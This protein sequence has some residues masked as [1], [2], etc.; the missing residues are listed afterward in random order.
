MKAGVP[1]HAVKL[2]VCLLLSGGQIFAQQPPRA[3]PVEEERTAVP[4]AVPVDSPS[5]ASRP[6]QPSA[7]A[8][9]TPRAQG[10]DE[11]L[12]EY[13]TL[14]FAQQD[15]AIAIKPLSDYVRTYPQGRHAA[16]ALFRL[17]ES[18]LKVGDANEAKKAYSDVITRY[19]KTESAASAA[20]RLGALIYNTK[21]FIKAAGYFETCAR[22]TTSA[23]VKLAALYN[24]ALCYKQ[25]DQ[26]AK[27]LAS[28][29]AVVAI[30]DPNQY[31]D[32]A[33]L[34]VAA[35]S[36][37]AGKKEEAL[38][39]FNQ[40]IE[41]NKDDKVIG[42]ALLKAGLILNEQGKGEAA[43][44]NFKRALDM[45]GLSSDQRGVA[46]FGLIQGY[47]VTGDYDNVIN[48]YSANASTLPPEDLRSKMLLLVGNAHKQKQ[49]YRQAV[50]VFLLLEKNHPDSPESL[51]AGYQKLL[52]FYQLG[53]KDVPVFS[54]RFEERYGDKYR[55]HEYLRMSRLI[56]A[57][58]Y[59]ANGKY[60]ES[61]VA[62]SGI[63]MAAVPPKVRA[64]VLYKKGFAEA[65][66][67]KSN[68]AISS[69][70]LYLTDYPKDD[71]A[72]LALAQRGISYKAVRS[73]DRALEDFRTIIKDYPGHSAAE[74][75]YYQSGL[76]KGETRDL[77]GM[78]ADLEA[79]VAKFPASPAAAESFFRIG[80]GYF[81]MK[82]KETYR[83]ALAPLRKSIELDSKEYLD[84]GSQLLIACQWLLEDVDGLANE[85]DKY[86]AARKDASITPKALTFL[87]VNYYNQGKFRES[88]RYLNI[89]STPDAPAN[90]EAV[91][92]DYLGMAEFE[93]GNHEAALKAFDNYLAQTPE[94]A[95]RVRALLN[96]SRAFLALGKFDEAETTAIEGLQV[97]RE[98]DLHAK[99]QILQ[100]DIAMAH[101]DALEAAGNKDAGSEEWKKAAGNFVVVSQ[102][103]VHPEITPEAAYKAVKALEKIGKKQEAD[104]LRK[105]LQSKYPNFQPK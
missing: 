78:V 95:G 52:C 93:G 64:N 60:V 8:A 21:D 3:V 76:I 102:F 23:D 94:G 40:I 59:F 89:A 53:D 56:R 19:P 6:A 2:A 45:K 39:F 96:K 5:S 100:G 29:K 44:K 9:A 31:K 33:L 32:T 84:K 55:K 77:A 15:Y 62:Y 61:A 10:P 87:G 72:P 36:L 65:E 88:A 51:E 73:F 86:L 54:E 14:C 35:G 12:Y 26:K 68:D 104:S 57:D 83:K 1:A 82:Q 101:G 80:K 24:T 92:W 30:K 43:M 75:A 47:F 70:S 105:Q 50:E 63:D 16:E 69:L 58:W 4:R 20:Y 17:G 74:M 46:V 91:V 34:E 49:N 81:D 79:L 99:L 67:G 90:T 85:V 13:A 37:E 66:A 27:A 25:G 42:D 7:G 38:G 11:D 97:A 28:F 103:Y 71:N 98:G 18:Q 22:L 41:T 48:T